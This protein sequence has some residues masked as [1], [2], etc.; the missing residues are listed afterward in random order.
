MTK[1]P[2]IG[3]GGIG[4]PSLPLHVP[5]PFVNKPGG[6]ECILSGPNCMSNGFQFREG[7]NGIVLTRTKIEVG[8]I[9]FFIHKG[10]TP[11]YS[12]SSKEEGKQK[13]EGVKYR[14]TYFLTQIANAD[15]SR[16]YENIEVIEGHWTAIGPMTVDFNFKTL[17]DDKKALFTIT[18]NGDWFW[19]HIP[20]HRENIKIRIWIGQ[21]P[22]PAPPQEQKPVQAT[23]RP[24]FKPIVIPVKLHEAKKPTVPVKLSG[25]PA[26]QA[27][28]KAEADPFADS[29]VLFAK[30]DEGQLAKLN[31]S[32]ILGSGFAAILKEAE[33]SKPDDQQ[34][35]SV[36]GYMS[37]DGK[38]VGFGTYKDL[39]NGAK[40]LLDSGSLVD[41]EVK[42]KVVS[43]GTGKN[44]VLAFH[45]DQKI[46]SKIEKSLRSTETELNKAQNPYVG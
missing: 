44:F 8:G 14:D 38:L 6:L 18:R 25:H 11:V 35:V 37:A 10:S 40:A 28:E 29:D 23:R 5:A 34:Y 33:K 4:Q 22:P 31:A 20:R 36:S 45:P 41:F 3:A 2:N 24:D 9:E 21:D 39:E 16:T 1:I 13:Q 27:T 42:V 17:A 43:G 26:K 7:I 46:S 12:T 15:P 32:K 30:I 19:V